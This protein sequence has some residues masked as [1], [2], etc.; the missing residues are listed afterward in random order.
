MK[1]TFTFI[2]LTSLLAAKLICAAGIY[3][4]DLN[5]TTSQTTTVSTEKS[6]STTEIKKT[7]TGATTTHPDQSN[8]KSKTPIINKKSTT[9]TCELTKIVLCR[10]SFQEQHE[11]IKNCLP[12]HIF[13]DH[14]KKE[15]WKCD[16]WSFFGGIM[17]TITILAIVMVAYKYVI[18]K[19][20]RGKNPEHNYSLM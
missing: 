16:G 3:D 14:H 1:Q 13:V 11:C 6:I 15:A 17:S 10:H 7:T 5:S 18:F 9:S 19:R 2:V 20:S 8:S 12:G 4:L